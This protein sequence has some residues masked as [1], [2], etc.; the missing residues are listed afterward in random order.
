MVLEFRYLVTKDRAD[1]SPAVDSQ[2]KRKDL[3]KRPVIRDELNNRYLV[4]DSRREFLEWYARVPEKERCCHE[5][6][7]GYLPQRIKFDI[8]APSHLVDSLPEATLAAALRTAADTLLDEGSLPEV[9]VATRA[10]DLGDYLD[11]L[12]ASSSSEDPFE[13]ALREMSTPEAAPLDPVE[14]G[15]R[16]QQAKI[17]AVVGLLIE[18]ILDELY[19][20]YYGVED[21]MPTREDLVVTDSSGPTAANGW[22]YSYHI[23]VLPYAVPD[24]QEAAE[25]TERVLERLP[26]P[27]HPFVD[28]NVNKKTQNFRLAG[29]A[30]PG[31]GRYKHATAEAARA[32]RTAAGVAL[33]DLFVTAASGARVLARVYTDEAVAQRGRKPRVMLGP[34]DPVVREVLD[35]AARAGV[36]AG[37]TL[38]EVRG[39]LLCFDRDEPTHCPICGEVH[40]KDN[41]LMLSIEP[42][43]AGHDGAWPGTGAVECRVVEHCRQA[44]GKGRVVGELTLDAAALRGVDTA[45]GGG[46]GGRGRRAKAADAGPSLG[47]REKVAARIAAIGEGRV[48]PHEALASE[49]ERL[50]ELQKTVYAEPAMRDYELTPTLAVLA[51]MKLGK[52]K[53]M[54]RYLDA[55][56]PADGLVTS[57]VRFV[58]FRQTFSR[59]LAEAFPDFALYT[60]VTGDLDAARHP[61]LI[62]QV[63]SLHRLRMGARPEP[64]DLLVLDEVESI[65]AQFNSGLHRHFTA[66]WAMFQWMLRT[67]RHVV[68]MDANLG[69]RTYNTLLRMRPHPPHF[70]W[71]RYARAAD[72]V[73]RFTADQGAWLARLHAA[74]RAGQRVVLPVN[75]LGEAKAF[76][77]GLRREFPRKKVMLYSSETAPSEKARHFGDVHSYWGDLDVLIYT[78]TCSAGVSFELE[79]FD[80][81][82]GFFCDASCDV[83]TCRQMLG[84]VRNIGTREHNICLRATGAALPAT[85]DEIR[86]LVYDKRAGL[87]RGIEDIALAYEYEADGAIRYYESDYFHLWL[88]TVRVGNLSRNSFAHRFIDQVADTGAQVGVLAAEPGLGAALLTSHR[89]T[90]TELKGARCEA[91]AAAPELSPCEAAQVREALQAQLDVEPA[92]RLGYEKY[93]LREAY[94]WHGRPLDAAFVAGYQPPEARRVYRNLCR[95]TEG[96][97]VLDSLR[98]MQQREA[99]HYD[100]TMETR[101]EAL[102]YVNESRDLLRE[103]STYVFQAHFLA[104]WLLRVCGW[105][106]VTD[107][108][109]VHEDSLEARLRA[110]I[111]ALR[112]ALDR[113]VFEFEIPR[114]KLDRLAREADRARFLAGMLRMVNA[115]L[116]AM[117]GLQVTRVAKRAGGRAY[118]LNQS[119]TG[120]LFVFSSTPEDDSA[121]DGPRPHIASNLLPLPARER[122]SRVNLFLEEAFYSGSGS[123]SGSGTDSP[124]EEVGPAH[125]DIRAE[126]ADRRKP[127]VTAAPK[128]AAIL[129]PH[130]YGLDDFLAEQYAISANA[131]AEISDRSRPPVRLRATP[132]RAAVVAPRDYGLDDF[133]A[134]QFDIVLARNSQS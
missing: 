74:V 72:D 106:C 52:T 86:R 2:F 134:E 115:V 121:P 1:D 112:R 34:Q 61:R 39:T 73:Y 56:F 75:S 88:E 29:S 60:D 114:P 35:L 17:E 123:G 50:P 51:Q 57:V 21:L 107:K 11:G 109:R 36:T 31:T 67:A 70:H 76:E 9:A 92:S 131:G 116:R 40:H 122:D 37:H 64:V 63:E 84:R 83:E 98:L 101:S 65:L 93:Q 55:H 27:L 5:V 44:R 68:C 4:F 22:K 85:T 30:K 14:L 12:L 91:V 46:G 89:E 71:N 48:N 108:G 90:R 100:F 54:R 41:S 19:V 118:Y 13:A 87:Y 26:K 130:D 80:A 24:H 49:F 103:K 62:V 32:F 119:A 129:A 99:H 15:R 96:P 7:F 10:D 104:I 97:T 110:A 82:F 42:V 125:F 132:T 94:A 127:S 117:Y 124:P 105:A 18:A 47:L 38:H 58:T 111:P 3:V 25:F 53:A 23:L 43:E 128:E 133:L 28:A 126:T 59:S 102:G 81:L 66:A 79:H 120:R 33:E 8:D 78:P 45:V 69:D 77:E 113:L 20:G 95:V 16:A 6:V